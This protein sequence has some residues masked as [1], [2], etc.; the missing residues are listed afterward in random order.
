MTKVLSLVILAI[1]AIQIIKPLGIPGLRRRRDFWKLALL[2]L[3]A[4]GVTV[5]ASHVN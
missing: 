4:I 1:M 2:A 5:L 3:G